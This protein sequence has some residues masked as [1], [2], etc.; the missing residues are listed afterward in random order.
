MRFENLSNKILK[1]YI[2][3]K[4][5]INKQ[6]MKQL[7]E[8]IKADPMTKQFFIMNLNNKYNKKYINTFLKL[9]NKYNLNRLKE[10]VRGGSLLLR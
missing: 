6:M 2:Q 1:Y 8:Y 5:Q 3:N 7:T 10:S 4:F 9:Y